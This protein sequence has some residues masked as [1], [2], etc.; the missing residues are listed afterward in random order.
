MG[1]MLKSYQKYK[2]LTTDQKLIKKL[3]ILEEVTKILIPSNIVPPRIY[4]KKIKL[5]T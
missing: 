5:S 3:G 2:T 4:V 1:V